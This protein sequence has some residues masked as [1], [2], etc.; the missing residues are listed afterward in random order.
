MEAQISRLGQIKMFQLK[1]NRDIIGLS[2]DLDDNIFDAFMAVQA[3]NNQ[4]ED[5]EIILRPKRKKSF[6]LDAI[7]A[8]IPFWLSNPEVKGGVEKFKIRGFDTEI[9]N[10][11][12]IDLLQNYLRSDRRIIQ[13][14]ARHRCVDF[15]SM[16]AG[17][18]DAYHELLPDIQRIMRAG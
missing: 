4:I 15:L 12:T 11:R 8:R 13:Q 6:D 14:D 5:F 16:Y 3:I 9:G 10:D 7:K 2:R 18:S 17:I 1:V